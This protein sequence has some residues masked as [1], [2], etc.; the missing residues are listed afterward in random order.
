MIHPRGKIL[1]N[2]TAPLRAEKHPLESQTATIHDCVTR[3]LRQ[4][5]LEKAKK[6][7]KKLQYAWIAKRIRRTIY[8]S[9]RCVQPV[10]VGKLLSLTSKMDISSVNNSRRA[11]V[12]T[13]MFYFNR[14]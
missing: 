9:T 8:D 12:V 1:K 5:R 13:M 3:I 4:K 2:C 10:G 11:L 7:M 14:S 6:V